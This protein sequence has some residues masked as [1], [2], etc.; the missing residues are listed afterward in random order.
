MT[1]LPGTCG[2]DDIL[3]HVCGRALGRGPTLVLTVTHTFYIFPDTLAFRSVT[4]NPL[5]YSLACALNVGKG[6]TQRTHKYIS[7]KIDARIGSHDK[8]VQSLNSLQTVHAKA[9]SEMAD[10]FRIPGAYWSHVKAYGNR[11]EIGH[12]SG[13]MHIKGY[14]IHELFFKNT[15]LLICLQPTTTHGT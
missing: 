9:L 3:P 15:Q 10:I 6:Q 11:F 4:C 12:R 8:K 1:T 2:G 7:I 14:F 13:R 5:Y